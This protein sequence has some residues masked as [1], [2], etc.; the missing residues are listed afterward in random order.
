MPTYIRTLFSTDIA[1]QVPDGTYGRIAP[2]SS[3]AV[4][5]SL[6]ISAGVI[7]KEYFYMSSVILIDN[8]CTNI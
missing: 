6:D 8:S 4:K 5:G 1:I 2:R 3:P 7:D